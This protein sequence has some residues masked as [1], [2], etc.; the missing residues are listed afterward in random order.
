MVGWHYQRPSSY[1][2]IS[3]INGDTQ[4]SVVKSFSP[5]KRL[6]FKTLRCYVTFL[7]L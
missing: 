5:L 3:H 2:I 4:F 1:S 7:Q 6:L